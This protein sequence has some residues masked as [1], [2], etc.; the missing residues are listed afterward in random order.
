MKTPRFE[1][2]IGACLALGALGAVIYAA[3][4]VSNEQALG[5][6]IAVAVCWV[7]GILASGSDQR[8]VLP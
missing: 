4:V 6:L 2:A 7:W 8:G 3:I 1:S 5:A